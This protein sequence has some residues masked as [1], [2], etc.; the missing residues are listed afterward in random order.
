[1]LTSD[2]CNCNWNINR[3]TRFSAKLLLKFAMPIFAWF[4]FTRGL[5]SRNFN[6]NQEMQHTVLL[7][8]YNF[9]INQESWRHTFEFLKLASEILNCNWNIN[10]STKFSYTNILKILMSFLLDSLLQEV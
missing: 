1:M 3:S 9:N 4:T 8:S 7:S 5:S 2:I 6:I 10:H